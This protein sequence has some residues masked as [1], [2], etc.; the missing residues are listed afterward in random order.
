MLSVYLHT[1]YMFRDAFIGTQKRVQ[2]TE[3]HRT[4]QKSH[5][6]GR[7]VTEMLLTSNCTGGAPGLGDA[8]VSQST[9]SAKRV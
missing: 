8:E 1:R 3:P 9:L 5:S 4:G 6:Y 7:K 2:L